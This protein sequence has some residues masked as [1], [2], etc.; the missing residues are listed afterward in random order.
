M[1]AL[2]TGRV[3][4]ATAAALLLAVPQAVQA[5]DPL[6]VLALPERQAWELD[7]AEGIV[8]D[9]ADALLFEAG[10]IT[11]FALPTGD[12]NAAEAIDSA[13]ADTLRPRDARSV[14]RAFLAEFF[15]ITRADPRANALTDRI[16]A[17]GVASALTNP[18]DTRWIVIRTKAGR[19]Y[20]ADH[21]PEGAPGFA[22]LRPVGLPR[23]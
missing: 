9:G 8:G 20:Y 18:G 7:G 17:E 6:V 21:A 5:A 11:R 13:A 19:L 15:P 4:A 2:A 1:A 10:G 23:F 14:T 12:V 3:T 22:R 16:F